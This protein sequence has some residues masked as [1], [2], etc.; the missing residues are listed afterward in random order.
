MERLD[1]QDLI[2]FLH[3]RRVLAWSA[4]ECPALSNPKIIFLFLDCTLLKSGKD[5]L[6]PSSHLPL[7][8]L[9]KILNNG[10][11]P[12][13]KNCTSFY[14]CSEGEARIVHCPRGLHFDPEGKECKSPCLAGCDSSIRKWSLLV[15]FYN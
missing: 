5:S 4:R 10:T 15:E 3:R 9:C 11:V 7:W 2:G 14:A 12:N 6:T 1:I 13:P 8:L